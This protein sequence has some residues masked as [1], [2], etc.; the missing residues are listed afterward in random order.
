MSEKMK[1]W[2]IAAG[3]LILTG[4]LVFGGVMTMLKWDFKKLSTVKYVVNEYLLTESFDHIEIKA[5][6]ADIE[7]VPAE[8]AK[9]TCYEQKEMKH[10]VT[11]E[12]N[13]LTIELIDT[14]KWYHYIGI[15]FDTPKV[16]VCL[17]QGAYGMLSIDASTGDVE[18]PKDLAFETMDIR[19]STGHVTSFASASGDVTLS[20]H[21]GD[22]RVEG[23]SAGSMDLS[24]TTGR[25]TAADLACKG[26]IRVTVSTG[27]TNMTNINCGNIIS[28]G[29]TGDIVME[30]AIAGERISIERDTGDVVFAR[31]DAAELFVNTDTGDVKGSLCSE[32]VFLAQS[33]TGRVDVPKTVSG[34][35]CE[36]TTNTGDIKIEIQ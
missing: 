28:V 25:V 35:R 23:A 32:K 27:H 11:V 26:D 18:I 13:T 12:D 9:V 24:V 19:L 31:C 17:P 6:T 22:I 33:D 4:C 34:G 10:A 7:F 8:T 2:L 20:T 3:A 29:N 36:I 16:T 30:N 5:D 14:R 15:S 21:T 1:G